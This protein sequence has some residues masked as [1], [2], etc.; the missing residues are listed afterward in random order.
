MK[1]SL[2]AILLAV[3]PAAAKQESAVTGPR[4]SDEQFF[5]MLDLAR[6][7]LTAVKS[8][9][10]KADY[11]AAKLAL[12]QYMRTRKTPRW[13][14]DPA[15][16]GSNKKF[17]NKT[18]DNVLA[19]KLIS[20]GIEWQFGEKIDWKFNPTTQSDSKWP[21]NNEWTWQLNRHDAWASLAY[22]YRSTGDEKYSREF[23]EQLK[24]WVRD[25]PVP[26]KTANGAGSTWRTIEAGIRTDG[27]WFD[28]FYSFLR[29]KS[30]DDDTLVLMLKSF[31]EHAQYLAQ[32]PSRTG[33]WL[34]ME[35]NGLYH[36][37]ALFPEFKD[38]EFWRKTG[39]ERLYRELDAQVYPDGVQMELAPGYHGVTVGNFLGPVDLVALT[40]FEIPRDYLGK[41]QRMFDYYLYSMQPTRQMPP[42]NDSS[43]KDIRGWMRRAVEYFPQREDFRWAATDGREG[44][45]PSV[46]SYEFP[47]AGQLI[48]RSGWGPKDL[49]LCMDAGPFG[50]AHQ[51]EDKLSI[52]LTAYGAPLLVEGGVYTYDAS[53]WRKYILSSRSH[54]LVM[55]DGLEQNRRVEPKETFVVSKPLPHLWR[56]DANR[57]DAQASYEEGWGPKAGRIVKHTRH[58]TFVK[59]AFFVV[60]DE[61]ESLDGKPH[62][63]ETIFHFDAKE[64]AV[65]GLKVATKST[66]PNLTILGVGADDVK[67][68]AG[69]KEPVVQGWLPSHG[70][71]GAVRPIPTAL[72]HKKAAGKIT[73]YYVLYP[74]PAGAT[75]PLKSATVTDKG[76]RITFTD[77]KETVVN[78][79]AA[80]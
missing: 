36:V 72:Y 44:K 48:M 15:A 16:T 63:Y 23:V 8:A 42:L 13:T 39:L 65:D 74:T 20:L 79:Y 73:Q 6:P 37:G 59:P 17:A 51:H 40:G 32:C 66:G 33:N 56:S 52:I 60:A 69:Q 58:V 68:V 7:E 43:A 54:N 12:A 2:F 11:P 28:V 14:I 35:S 78:V 18:V 10:A 34:I 27:V 26:L 4:L 50:M 76:L 77:G 75:C 9:V 71:Y 53:E 67:I 61:L 80:K 38:A 22:A 5:A 19:H 30:F 55:V 70:E 57:D 21:R 24:G 41:L 64:A 3:A 46:M 29:S 62:E 45:P 31:V 1:L 49:W 47:Y 25:C